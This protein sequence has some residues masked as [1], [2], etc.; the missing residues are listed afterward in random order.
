MRRIA[1][2]GD[3]LA[4][5]P[6]PGQSFPARLQVS[7]DREGLPYR[8][9]N[10]GVNGDTT[11]GGVRRLSPLLASDV[12]VLIVAL[13][14]NDGLAGIDVDTIE[15]N[16]S[17]IID[18]AQKAGVLVLLCGMEVPPVH[19]WS[20]SVS[21]HSLFRRLAARYSVPLVPFLL[22][23]VALVPELNGADGVHP[24]AAGAQRIADTVWP[25]LEPLLRQSAAAVP[26]L[27]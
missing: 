15:G 13:G 3:S 7:L 27:L 19:G 12:A 20:Y 25:Y 21:F 9:T 18:T 14:S 23:G 26:A 16:L 4:V 22:A 10:A 24:N 11:S 17:T 6:S 2:L 8:V 5:S 1:V